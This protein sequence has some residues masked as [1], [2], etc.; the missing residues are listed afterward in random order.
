MD[1]LAAH[2]DLAGYLSGQVP[3]RGQIDYCQALALGRAL[4]RARLPLPQRN[5]QRL[6]LRGPLVKVIERLINNCATVR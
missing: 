4:H 3:A 1:I 6:H 2:P 5:A